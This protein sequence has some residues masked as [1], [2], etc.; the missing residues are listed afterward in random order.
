MAERDLSR[1]ELWMCQDCMLLE[2]TGDATFLDYHLTPRQADA[3]LKEIEAGWSALRKQGDVFNDCTEDRQVECA[4]CRH[5]A[6]RGDVATVYH[7]EYDEHQLVCPDCGS[8]DEMRDR[9]HGEDE[10]SFHEC[11]CCGS[12][13]GG[14]RHRYAL[15]PRQ[16]AEG[17]PVVPGE[18]AQPAG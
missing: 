6:R 1:I 11:D 13:L 4:E 15:F 18:V 8:V 3:R 12:S 14:S 10:F 5:I 16:P 17:G 7:E 2:E 9:D